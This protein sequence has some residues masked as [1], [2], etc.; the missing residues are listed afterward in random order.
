MNFCSIPKELNAQNRR[1]GHP[2]LNRSLAAPQND[3]GRLA[4]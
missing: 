4:Y 3:D 1:W 2:P